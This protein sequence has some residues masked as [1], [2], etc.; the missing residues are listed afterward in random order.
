MKT[1]TVTYGI[2]YGRHSLDFEVEDDATEEDIETYAN[3]AVMERVD[4]GWSI[5]A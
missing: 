5:S 3:E 2:G 4:Y 1:V